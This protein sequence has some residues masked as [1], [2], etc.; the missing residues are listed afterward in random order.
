MEVKESLSKQLSEKENEFR[1]FQTKNTNEI[2][3]LTEE[4]EKTKTEFTALKT[5]E[6]KEELA[7]AENKMV[8]HQVI[9]IKIQFGNSGFSK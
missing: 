2:K 5:K 8:M 1:D 4:L 6:Q 9:K 7:M 3:R